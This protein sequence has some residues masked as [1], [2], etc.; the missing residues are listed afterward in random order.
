MPRVGQMRKRITFQTRV[1]AEYETY[2]LNSGRANIATNPTVWARVTNVTGTQQVDSRNA[3]EGVTHR[4]TIRFRTDITKQLEIL[5]DGKR[6][7]IAT[8][9]VEDDERERF[10]IIEANEQDV[11]GTLDNPSP[12]S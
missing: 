5:Y 8:I 3:G 4:F 9:Q 12:E 2:S 11:V 1:E 7:R 6:Y 10:L